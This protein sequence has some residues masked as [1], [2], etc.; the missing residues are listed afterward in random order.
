MGILKTSTNNITTEEINNNNNNYR[1]LSLTEE[2]INQL[3]QSITQQVYNE[4]SEYFKNNS[5]ILESVYDKE[6]LD[7]L[8]NFIDKLVQE[9][10]EAE[11]NGLI[12][13]Y[14]SESDEVNDNDNTLLTEEQLESF[15]DII[16]NNITVKTMAAVNTITSILSELKQIEESDISLAPE[17]VVEIVEACKSRRKKKK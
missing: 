7:V 9:S 4:L 5:D 16:A 13:L 2:Q 11:I 10:I 1:A 8:D 17:T 14:E 15:K 3:K 12:Q 6:D